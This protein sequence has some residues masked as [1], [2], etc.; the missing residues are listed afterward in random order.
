[1]K[2]II[3]NVL[4]L[5]TAVF[6]FYSCNRI[7]NV[8][9]NLTEEGYQYSFTI[10]EDLLATRA[11][12]DAGGVL[13]E[14][15]DQVGMYIVD[16][17]DNK[18]YTGYANIDVTTQPKTVILYSKNA[19]PA[20]SVAY[21]YY[22]YISTNDNKTA[23]VVYFSNTQT[24]GSSSVMPM[25]G[26]PFTV[27]N[28]VEVSNG[29]AKTNGQINFLN[30]G[31]I[32]DFK[33]YSADYSDETVQYVTFTADNANVSGNATLN[34]TGVNATNESTLTLNWEGSETTYDYAKVNQEVAVAATK[35]AATSI[36]MVVA[37]GTY[38]GTITI[39]TDIATYTFMYSDKE[40]ARNVI[41]HYN[42][43]LS[44]ATRVAEVIET[45]KSLP[46]SETFATGIGEFT[47]DDVQ[48]GNA[49][50]WQYSSGYM[51]ANA[52]VGGTRYATESWLTSPWIDLTGVS[53]AA[54]TFDH[55]HRY[56]NTPAD[57]LTFWVLTDESGA[58]WE[59]VTIPTYASGKDWNFVNSGE[60][61]L[62]SY[63]GH[64]VKIGFKYVSLAE[65]N[66]CA[67][68]QIKNVSVTEKVYTTEFT[69]DA[70]AITIEAGRTRNNNVTVNSGA[71]ITYTSGDE[72]IAT[73][74]S[75]GTVTG[76]AEG[77]TTISYEVAANGLY[78]AASG[79]FSV[80]VV[81]AVSYSSFTWDLSKN[82]TV[83][84]TEALIGWNYRGVTMVSEH[85]GTSGT[86]ANNYYGG[87]SNNRTSTRFYAG[88]SLVI[89]PYA[90]S[91]IGYVEFNATSESYGN[92]LKNSTWTN[93][94]AAID[95]TTYVVTVTPEDGTSAFSVA[96]LGGT[97]GFTAVTVYYT[98]DLEPIANYI[99]NWTAPTEGGCS[100]T[101]SAGGSVIASGDEVTSGTEV[102]LVAIA[103][104][105][106]EF[107]S[108]TVTDAS[109]NPITVSNNK[110]TMPSSNVTISA[111]F[112]RLY[113]IT[114]NAAT[115][116]TISA[117]AAKATAG[118]AITL[119]ATPNSGYQLSAWTVTD[120][121]GNN[122][123]VTNSMFTMP[124]GNVTVSATFA[125]GKTTVYTLTPAQSSANTAYASNYDVTISGIQWSVPGNQSFSGYWRIGGKSLTAVDR[126]IYG[127]G[128][129][130]SDVDEIVVAT[131]GISNANL[132]IN[133]I[134]VTAHA[135]AADAAS[136]SNG[137]TF[138]T[139][140]NLDFSVGTAKSL[141]F[142]KN[143]STNCSGYY[144]RIVF[145]L[146]NNKT[147]N[148]GLDLS[149]ITFYKN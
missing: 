111:T 120:A 8:P 142:N 2:K 15:G 58:S 18:V 133:S 21:A 56:E 101:V 107:T 69:K 63:V 143:G 7:E 38:S 74:A 106:Y 98:G 22:P 68:W 53:A 145:N 149:G 99:V 24:G 20:G 33:I 36:Y 86:A 47:T 29:S 39:G 73:V 16:P 136:G 139:S 108:W 19:I 35:D 9:S 32:I 11:T 59:Q 62:N 118:T 110:F 77:V 129:L 109:N 135:T 124:A 34:L 45:V 146:T 46:Y 48:A 76:V 114:C 117:S 49:D 141:T 132:T 123:I 112:T 131:N 144:Y 138:T 71:T 4:I 87:D 94:T 64:K 119:T 12:L 96:S 93:A 130:S 6:S 30:L 78:P 137:V 25:V 92:A 122:V 3:C 85:S 52:Y 90:G 54:V 84:A 115:N 97:C 10:S 50:V 37:P 104:T 83:T 14:Q 72:T 121:S 103:G 43:N 125:A 79:S 80:T 23:S 67:A 60:I 51:K 40:L 66:K 140:D 41:K 113:T 147:S 55:V 5:F 89:T 82:Q 75:D 126:V 13:W 27:E 91:T 70:D 31:S 148:Y 127:K 28:A 128:S 88:N 81:P 100:F 95:A 26:V 44:N 61:L 134:T 105:D 42:M 116:G 57:R 17:E 1:M 65:Q 102:T